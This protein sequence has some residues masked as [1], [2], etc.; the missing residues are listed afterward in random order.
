MHTAQAVTHHFGC[1]HRF[2][3]R[4]AVRDRFLGE[5]FNSRLDLGAFHV[6]GVHLLPFCSTSSDVG[7]TGSGILAY[8]M[9]TQPNM[10]SPIP[11]RADAMR[12]ILQAQIEF[13][14]FAGSKLFPGARRRRCASTASSHGA[15]PPPGASCRWAGSRWAIQ[16]RSCRPTSTAPSGPCR[17]KLDFPRH[18]FG[19]ERP[20]EGQTIMPDVMPRYARTL[21]RRHG[22]DRV[23]ENGH[24]AP[25][26][27]DGR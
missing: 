12:H 16:P 3:F 15:L 9:K 7:W 19:V 21:V 2:G 26:D 18:V 1:A 14:V 25:S 27:E 6:L 13:D 4:A 24:T 11:S 23:L 5:R 22:G 17:R 20:P 8:L 10:P